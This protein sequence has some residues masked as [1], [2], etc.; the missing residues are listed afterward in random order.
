MAPRAIQKLVNVAST[1]NFT[2]LNSVK[3]KYITAHKVITVQTQIG[4]AAVTKDAVILIKT[5]N[6]ARE[7]P[8]NLSPLYL[9]SHQSA[10]LESTAPKTQN[11]YTAEAALHESA[12]KA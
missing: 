5:S 9:D 10:M 4:N 11:V 12:V 1:Y 3:L 6:A 7:Y 8:R 2:H